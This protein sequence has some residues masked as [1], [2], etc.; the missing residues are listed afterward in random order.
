MTTF[1]EIKDEVQWHIRQRTDI[2]TFVERKINQAVI[3]VMLLVKPP[4]FFST[5]TVTTTAGTPNYDLES[6]ADT[7]AVIGVSITNTNISSNN[8]RLHRGHWDQFDD[9]DQDFS[10]TGPNLGRPRRYFRYEDEIIFYD[11]VPDDN[12]GNDYSIRVRTLQR[13]TVMTADSDTFPLEIEWEEPVTLRAAYKLFTLTGDIERR[14]ET[15]SLFQ[16][17]VAFVLDNSRDIETRY[18]RDASMQQ[19]AHRQRPASGHM[20]GTGRTG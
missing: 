5:V 16:E 17:S 11:K 20:G 10:T 19:G 15:K 6:S 2:E 13:P 3:D 9:A 14:E 12:D 4:E 1:G 8:R 18:D 7:L